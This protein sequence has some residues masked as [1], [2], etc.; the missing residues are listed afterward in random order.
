MKKR[1]LYKATALQFVILLGL[2]SF[3]A[4]ITYEGARSIM[5]QYLGILGAG[6]IAIS[7]I[8]GFGEMIGYFLRLFSGYIADKTKRYWT[9]TI[10]GYGINLVAVPLL[11]LAHHWIAAAILIILERSGK[12]I[13]TPARDAMLSYATKEMGRG[14]GFGIHMA[15]D[16]AGGV[17][18]PLFVTGILLVTGSYPVSFALLSIP[19]ICAMSALF[20][21]QRFFPKPQDLEVSISHI[22]TKGLTRSFWLYVIAASLVAMGYVDFPLIAYHFSKDAIPEVVIPLFYSTAMAVSGLS[23]LIAGRLYDRIGLPVLMCTIFISAFFSPL[24]FLDRGLFAF[25]G[26]ILWGI[27]MGTQGSILRAIVANLVGHSKRATAYGVLNSSFGICWFIGSVIIGLLY[28][29]S[30]PALVFF[31]VITQL[32]AIPILLIIKK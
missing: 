25:F 11:A 14:W 1:G 7:I 29:Y 5:G 12:A 18:G 10:L 8:A 21:A 9:I 22:E 6:A 3:F 28:Q 30:I 19:A 15:M 2:V 27:G 24:V 20:V 16:Q 13:R 17:L 32:A 26:V 23:A 4:D 31:S